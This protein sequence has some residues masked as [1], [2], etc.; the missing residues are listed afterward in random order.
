M[1]GLCEE[2]SDPG[3]F[4]EVRN[5]MKRTGYWSFYEAVF[6]SWILFRRQCLNLSSIFFFE[7]VTKSSNDWR[8]GW[9]NCSSNLQTLKDLSCRKNILI[10][11]FIRELEA[12]SHN[13]NYGYV[14]ARSA[15]FVTSHQLRF[16]VLMLAFLIGQSEG[17]FD[18]EAEKSSSI[19]CTSDSW[20]FDWLSS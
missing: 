11:F 12:F 7:N 15:K 19:N 8:F 17:K 3:H 13:Y 5:I 18:R 10:F 6:N 14:R 20:F 4:W 9:W 2:K 1:Y 16:T